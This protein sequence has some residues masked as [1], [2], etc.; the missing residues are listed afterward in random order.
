MASASARLCRSAV[1]S[2]LRS[3]NALLQLGSPPLHLRPCEVPVPVVD[4]LELAAMDRDARRRDK[5]HLT[6]ELTKRA[7]TL[8]SPGRDPCGSPQSSCD[9]ARAG[10]AT[11]SPR[12]SVR[13]LVPAAGSTEP[14]SDI[15]RC[16]ASG[17]P[18]DDTTDAPSPPRFRSKPISAKSSVST[19]TSITRTGLLSPMKSSRHSGS[20]VDCPRSAC[21]TKRLISFPRRIARES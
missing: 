3:C 2:W 15:R 18:T 21:S 16:I 5:A 13:L 4:G 9:Q 20:S 12:H 7:Q 6:A 11:T 8:R 19:N 17:E 10:P 1:S 14:G